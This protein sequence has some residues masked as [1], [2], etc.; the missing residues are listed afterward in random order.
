MFIQYRNLAIKSF[1]SSHPLFVYKISQVGPV[2][3][4]DFSTSPSSDNFSILCSK[5]TLKQ[6]L[7]LNQV[8]RILCD[9]DIK[10]GLPEKE[11]KSLAHFALK[12]AFRGTDT[13]LC[14]GANGLRL[15]VPPERRPAILTEAHNLVRYKGIIPTYFHIRLHFWWPSMAEDT[16]WYVRTCHTCQQ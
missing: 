11:A 13:L 3:S 15:V 8:V 12:F 2:F 1:D 14:K 6:D 7:K 16:V 9:L 10:E 4:L 5:H